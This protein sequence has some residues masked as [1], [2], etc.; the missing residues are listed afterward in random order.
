MNWQSPICYQGLAASYICYFSWVVELCCDENS[1][2]N[3]SIPFVEPW[4]QGLILSW[5]LILSYYS[6]KHDTRDCYQLMLYLMD[7]C[8]QKKPP[9]IFRIFLEANH[10]GLESTGASD[11]WWLG[12]TLLHRLFVGD[13]TELRTHVATRAFLRVSTATAY[14]NP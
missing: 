3:C 5:L 9:D 10:W 14:E 12:H 6:L 13:P 11:H 7:F 2:G 1:S 8:S 4:V